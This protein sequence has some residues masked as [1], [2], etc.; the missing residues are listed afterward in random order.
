MEALCS[1]EKSADTQRTTRCYI[2][3]DGTLKM[4][5]VSKWDI[6]DREIKELRLFFLWRIRPSGLFPFRIILKL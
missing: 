4:N 1:T 6:S 2:P 5:T 3:E